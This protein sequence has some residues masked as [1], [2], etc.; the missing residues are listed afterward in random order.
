MSDLLSQLAGF[1]R[2]LTA[3]GVSAG[4]D[5]AASFLQALGELDVT[6]PVDVYWAG[7]ATLTAHPDDISVY[8]SV[9][10]A[11]FG[12]LQ[13]RPGRPAPPPEV[14][15]ASMLL[16]TGTGDG[17]DESGTPPI[18]ATAVDT[19]V[20]RHKDIASMSDAERAELAALTALLAPGLP[21]RRSNRHRASP[22]GRVDVRRTVRAMVAAG[23]EPVRLARR[24]RSTRPR[25]VVLL[26]DVSGSM[27][28]YAETLLRFAHV[29]LRQRPGSVEVFTVGTR[30]SRLTKALTSV[31][32]EQ[33]LTEAAQVI[34]DWSGGTRLGE[35]L[36]AFTDR[37]G[38]RG[39][40]RGS[41]LV[42]FSDGWERGDPRLLGEQMARLSR[43]ARRTVWVNP[44]KG[45]DGYAPIQGG[46]L[47]VLPHVDNFLAGHTLATLEELV[48]VMADA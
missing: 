29:L 43:L 28:P 41:V 10:T 12:G 2:A 31:D 11:W 39:T 45:K 26:I 36:K 23:G 18:R 13:V 22:H 33:A 42:V 30:L 44:H 6:D 1:A 46:I 47:A 20:L 48:A 8:D 16:S 19:E 34:P 37:W 38:Q 35:G 4:P 32:P 15:R 3:A 9:F 5:R 7:R 24:R 27:T 25:R 17:P 14:V 21:V 40:A